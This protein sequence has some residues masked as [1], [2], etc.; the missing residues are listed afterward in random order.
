MGPINETVLSRARPGAMM[1]WVAGA[2]LGA[3]LHGTF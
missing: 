3:E 2:R 1:I